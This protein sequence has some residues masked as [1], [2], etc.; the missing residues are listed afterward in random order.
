MSIWDDWFGADPAKVEQVQTLSGGQQGLQ[1][2]M[3]NWAM[4]MFESGGRTPGWELAAGPGGTSQA[5][6]GQGPG[7]VNQ[8][9]GAM[10]GAMQPLNAQSLQQGSQPYLDS[11]M[12]QFQNQVVPQI[13]GQFGALDSAR[14]SGMANVMGRQAS[15]LPGMAQNQFLN[16][17]AGDF[18]RG[19]QG[20]GMGMNISQLQD[21]MM[22]AQRQSATDLWGMSRPGYERM[23]MENLAGQVFGTPAFGNIGIPGPD[24]AGMMQ[25]MGSAA[26]SIAS[27]IALSDVRCKENVKPIDGALNKVEHLVGCSYNYKFNSQDNRNGGVMA[28][29]V[30]RVLP[31]AVSEV[32]G[33]KFVRYDAVIG[34]LVNAVNELRQEIR[35]K[36]WVQAH[37]G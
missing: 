37:N 19:L 10:Q 3:A 30:E 35:S 21:A 12:G 11:M 14:S 18:S 17:R 27:L 9:A 28:Q 22:Q 20:M 33:V 6:Y 5:M 1:N 24:V 29:D 16:Q 36:S 4:K 32:N 2:M 8:G 15:Q 23:G 13:A 7:M 34:L 31:D 26:G 25:G